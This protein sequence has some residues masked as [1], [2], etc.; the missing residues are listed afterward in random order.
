[1]RICT[2]Q[3]TLPNNYKPQPE[4]CQT[5]CLLADL[6]FLLEVYLSV[7]LSACASDIENHNQTQVP[8]KSWQ[9]LGHLRWQ[10]ESEGAFGGEK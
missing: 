2:G 3:D 9:G 1:M 6:W 7:C 8:K 4:E 10:K 5:M